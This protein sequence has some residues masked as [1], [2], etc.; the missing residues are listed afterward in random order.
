M[1]EIGSQLR[2]R[3]AVGSTESSVVCLTDN[4]LSSLFLIKIKKDQSA[5]FK[6]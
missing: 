1:G 6:I 4:I 2:E 5:D 3:R